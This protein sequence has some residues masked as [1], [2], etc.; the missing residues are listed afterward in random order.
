MKQAKLNSISFIVLFLLLMFCSCFNDTELADGT[1]TSYFKNS[2]KIFCT[3]QY[4]GGKRNGMY[5][6]YYK[7]G[8]LRLKRNYVNDSIQ[9]T[10]FLFHENGR[11]ALFQ[12]ILKGQR[13]SVWKKYSK[14]GLLYSEVGYKNDQLDGKTV[15]HTYQS[16]RLLDSLNYKEGVLDGKQESFYDNGKPK[17]ILYFNEGAPC[18]GTQEW[19][20]MGETVKNDFKIY[21]HEENKVLM[22]NTLKFIINLENCKADDEVWVVSDKDT[23]NVVTRMYRLTRSGNNFEWSMPVH[24]GGFVMDHIKI[25]AFRKTAMGNMFIKTTTF[26]ASANNF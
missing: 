1:K 6:E 12:I 16:G 24:R 15:T 26:I 20:D 17:N 7:N 14:E 4:K 21:V 11:L 19:T 10:T 9:D 5:L 18:F 23:G 13:E 3:T 22:E 25:A 2:K 8:H